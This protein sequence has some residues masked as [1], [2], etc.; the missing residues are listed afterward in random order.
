MTDPITL[1]L[2]HG[3]GEDTTCPKA[4][5]CERHVGLRAREFPEDAEMVGT[6]CATR[7]YVMF[8]PLT[9]VA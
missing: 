6:A 9:E 4:D 1:C 3:L 5:Q 8:L 7:D 2:A